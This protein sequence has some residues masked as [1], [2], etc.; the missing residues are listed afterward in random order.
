MVRLTGADSGLTIATIRLAATTLPNPMLTKRISIANR[1]LPLSG[2]RLTQS[3][4]QLFYL[5]LAQSLHAPV[6]MYADLVHDA[7]GRDLSDLR[8]R[9]EQ[10]RDTHSGD[11][12]VRRVLQYRTQGELARL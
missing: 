2:S 6:L 3:P 1:R 4:E 9:L 11:H 10:V 12:F 5:A 8:Q 7:L